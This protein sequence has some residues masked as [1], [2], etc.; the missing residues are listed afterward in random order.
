MCIPMFTTA[1]C[2]CVSLPKDMD[3]TLEQTKEMNLYCHFAQGL[4]E[5]KYMAAESWSTLNKTLLEGL[6]NYNEINATLNL[7]LFEDAMAHV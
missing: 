1:I 5:A 2:V 6:D 3:E 7:V 4:G